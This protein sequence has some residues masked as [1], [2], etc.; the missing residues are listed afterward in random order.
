M[1]HV[2]RQRLTF[3]GLGFF[4][5]KTHFI[6]VSKKYPTKIDLVLAVKPGGKSAL[7]LKMF[8]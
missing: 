6:F 2:F 3:G 8:K 7:V 1:L 4:S 5:R